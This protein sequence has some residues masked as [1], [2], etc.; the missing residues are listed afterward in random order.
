[1]QSSVRLRG[2]GIRR[3]EYRG[4][5]RTW[6]SAIANVPRLDEEVI[7]ISELFSEISQD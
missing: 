3:E 2:F 5:N 7:A 4:C 1:M 6:C